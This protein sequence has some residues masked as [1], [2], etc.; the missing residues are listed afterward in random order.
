MR[1]LSTRGAGGSK[2]FQD[3]ILEGLAPD[4]GLYLPDH[5]PFIKIKKTSNYLDVAKTVTAPFA[6]GVDFK[7]LLKNAWGSFPKN[8]PA[9]LN[10]LND[11]LYLMELFHGPTLSFKDFGLQFLGALFENFATSPLNIIGATSGD[12][13]A[14]AVHALKG[15]EG[16]RLFMLHPKGKISELQRRQMTTVKAPNI[17]NI[18]VEG[19]FDD[20]QRLLKGVLAAGK[21]TTVNSINWGRIL[22]QTTYYWWAALRLKDQGPVHL[23]V[24]SGN[25]GNAFSGYVAMKCGAPISGITIATNANDILPRAFETGIYKPGKALATISP[26][27]DI[28]VANNFE[29]LLFEATSRDP[30]QVLK[31]NRTLIKE[32]QYQIPEAAFKEMK[33]FFRAG[34]ASED[35]TNAAMKECHDQLGSKIDPHT[36]V[37]YAVWSQLKT[38]PSGP[39]VLLG[40]AHPGKFPE[41]Q[42]H[43]NLKSMALPEA[44]SS[45]KEAPETC[46]TI[47][48]EAR[49]LKNFIK[50]NT[51]DS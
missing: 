9:H 13:G 38:K 31:A 14:A 25:F 39:T 24:P 27:M 28:Q 48:A 10:K 51:H 45:L 46:F 26:A 33:S 6:P 32:G 50:E 4:G 20:C 5:Y 44:L 37:G 16:V 42:V 17:F 36:A 49:D 1:Y 47:K 30:E 43:T 40:T 21:F 8:D 23:V 2:S 18:A 35:Q 15:K 7:S 34:C 11:D 22:A 19:D 12:T 41:S 3:I 29:R